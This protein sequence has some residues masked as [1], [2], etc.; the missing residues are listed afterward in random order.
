MPTAVH[1]SNDK[2]LVVDE[3][4]QTVTGALHSGGSALVHPRGGQ[5]DLRMQVYAGTITL[6]EELAEGAGEPFAVFA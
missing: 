4:F 2:T 6:V 3:D 5:S 1:F